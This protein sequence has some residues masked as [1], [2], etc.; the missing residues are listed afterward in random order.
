MWADVRRRLPYYVSDWTDALRGSSLQVAMAS[1]VQIFFINL[2]PAI[3]YVLDMYDRTDGSYGV[4]EVILA[5]ALAAIVFS[6]FSVQPL[7][8]VG[9]TGL[10][11]L[12]NY[13]VYDIAHN[14]YG[15]NRQEYLRLQCWMLIWGAGF[16]FLTAIFNLCD[17]TRFVT[18]MISDTFGLYVGVIYI[19]KGIELLIREFGPAPLDNATGWLAVTIAVL[20][21]VTV[22]FATMVGASTYL[23]F[24]LRRL[25]GQLAFVAGCLFWTGFSNFPGHTLKDVSV[26][27]LPITRSFF[28][29]LDRDWVVDFWNAEVQWVFVGAP[30]GFLL[31]LLFYFDHNVSSV[32]AQARKFPIVKPAG[33]HWDFFL[34]GCTTFVSGI[35]G[36]PVPNGLVPQAPYHTDSLAVYTQDPI[37]DEEQ[38]GA[39]RVSLTGNASLL[40]IT[41]FAHVHIARV[42]EQRLSHF[43][44]GLLTIGAMT[45]PILVALGTMPRAVFAG[46]FLV[47]GW[48]S[49]ESNPIILRTL[50]LLQDRSAVPM[51]KSAR[52]PLMQLRRRTIA[53]FV[54]IQWVFFGM[55]I[56]IS[57][58]IAAIGFPV[59]I[60]LMIPC[61]VYF[62]PRL[63]APHELE[64]LDAPTATAPAVMCSLGVSQHSA[65]TKRQVERDETA[66][67]P[68]A[69]AN[70]T[71]TSS[72]ASRPSEPIFEK[73]PRSPTR[74][75]P[76]TSTPPDEPPRPSDTQPRTQ[77][78]RHTRSVQTMSSNTTGS[79][80]IEEFEIP[81]RTGSQRSRVSRVSQL[82][83]VD[84]DES[85]EKHAEEDDAME[86]RA[87]KKRKSFTPRRRTPSK[88]T[89]EPPMH[90]SSA[91]PDPAP[92]KPEADKPTVFPVLRGLKK[93]SSD[94]DHPAQA[95][96]VR[97]VRRTDRDDSSDDEPGT[98]YVRHEN[99]PR[100]PGKGMPGIQTWR[101]LSYNRN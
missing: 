20:F 92:T 57:Q 3:A 28:P 44:I 26:S 88:N 71:H 97:T 18:D 51:A 42:V 11:N 49:V 35:L 87:P 34:L 72:R 37:T 33:F 60:I 45:R 91:T 54:G 27:R 90:A 30:L 39:R 36:L 29:T 67:K 68:P 93:K 8:F 85:A 86:E 99:P 66:A 94:L 12:M 83:R 56:A 19:Q 23:P 74:S 10:T 80:F 41:H 24:Q 101:K 98:E 17:Y 50:S 43:V 95:K 61:R 52:P 70:S 82:P 62:V 38:D 48:A 75:V 6:L 14:H 69:R 25:V 21:S 32:M 59:I 2:M 53:L 22:Y 65:E 81:V 100:G 73:Q 7:T 47:V 9:V 79:S 58:T 13:T 5:S 96:R 77:G 4:N 84:Q 46:V 63:F 64:T 40:Y 1:V 76:S 78:M 16:H 31:T 15:L 89:D 55:T